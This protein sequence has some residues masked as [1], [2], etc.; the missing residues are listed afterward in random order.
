M[1]RTAAKTA[2][3][4]ST[5]PLTSCSADGGDSKRTALQRWKKLEK[6]TP[7][8]RFAFW[9]N[10]LSPLH[11]LQRLP[12]CLPGVHL[13]KVRVR[14][15]ESAVANKANGKLLRGKNVPHHPRIPCCRPLHRLRRVLPRLPAAHSAAP[16]NRK[17][18]KDIDTFYGEY[19]G[20]A[21]RQ[22][23]ADEWISLKDDRTRTG[24]PKGVRNAYVRFKNL[25]DSLRRNCPAHTCICRSINKVRRNFA[26]WEGCNAA[27][28]RS[29]RSRSPKDIS[30]RRAKTLWTRFQKRT[31][32]SRH[33]KR[34][35]PEFRD[36]GVRPAMFGALKVLDRVFLAE[37]VD[38]AI[39]KT[40]ANTA[41]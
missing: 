34:M 11:P 25:P 39:T 4:K 31:S 37:P 27:L 23:R 33:R 21:R 41:L 29:T 5:S 13:R 20:G 6:M 22:P 1:L 19:P 8:E 7:D 18:I 3:P 38:T 28:R 15:P 36:F 35:R 9:Q 30:S 12:R 40:A 26:A 17:F 10:E 2:S 32:K 24:V 14:Q 16:F